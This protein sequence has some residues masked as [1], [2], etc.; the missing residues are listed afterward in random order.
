[1]VPGGTEPTHKQSS[2]HL[3][4]SSWPESEKGCL[5][6]NGTGLLKPTHCAQLN[7]RHKFHKETQSQ[8]ITESSSW[9]I[10]QPSFSLEML[11]GD[12]C[13]QLEDNAKQPTA[14]TEKGWKW[15]ANSHP[16]H[17]LHCLQ[18]NRVIQIPHLSPSVLICKWSYY[19]LH[20]DIAG[21]KQIRYK[22]V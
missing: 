11:K 10:Q 1:M 21:L 19:P 22:L 15:K 8:V 16:L 12:A 3:P 4:L 6:A 9:E 5:Y 18:A 20:G 13:E 17:V 14:A 2:W 7:M